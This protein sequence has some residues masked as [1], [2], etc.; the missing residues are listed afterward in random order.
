[1]LPV[2]PL[3]PLAMVI[4]F[5]I[6]RV[7]SSPR[8]TRMFARNFSRWSAFTV[9]RDFTRDF[10]SFMS[11]V[12]PAPLAANPKFSLFSP[13]LPMKSLAVAS[14]DRWMMPWV[15]PSPVVMTRLC[16]SCMDSSAN[17]LVS[18]VRNSPPILDPRMP[19]KRMRS[20]LASSNRTLYMDIPVVAWRTMLKNRLT[21][22]PDSIAAEWTAERPSRTVSMSEPSSSM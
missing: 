4:R 9:A 13:I 19:P 3:V 15:R 8:L 18:F 20:P 11:R 1:M 21:P 12:T 5:V 10:S 7:M 14:A 2:P 16:R 22:K 6:C 17:P